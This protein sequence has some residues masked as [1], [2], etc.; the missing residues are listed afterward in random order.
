MPASKFTRRTGKFEEVG[1]SFFS[2]VGSRLRKNVGRFLG[3][4][5]VSG[6]FGVLLFFGEEEASTRADG[7]RS[8]V[9]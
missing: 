1:L 7:T 9:Q 8:N 6:S 4:D 3:S 2:T 5:D